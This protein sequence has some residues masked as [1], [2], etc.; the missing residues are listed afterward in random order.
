MS[1]VT[2]T[3]YTYTRDQLI[4]KW[5]SDLPADYIRNRVC[6]LFRRH[7]GCR[8]GQRRKTRLLFCRHSTHDVD[9]GRIPVIIGNRPTAVPLTRIKYVESKVNGCL[10]MSSENSVRDQLKLT[11]HNSHRRYMSSMQQHSPSHLPYNSCLLISI[12]MT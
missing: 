10:C 1:D 7:R 8:A 11:S 12:T 3:P 5:H 4:S 9:D 6:Q 2:R